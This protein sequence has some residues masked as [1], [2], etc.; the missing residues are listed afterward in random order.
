MSDKSRSMT[1]LPA[2]CIHFKGSTKI[3]LTL[4]Y[5]IQ[6][7]KVMQDT[8]HMQIRFRLKQNVNYC[9]KSDLLCQNWPYFSNCFRNLWHNLQAILN[10]KE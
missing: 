5:V 10:L 4:V 2:E 6:I 8:L 1:H 3:C 9:L 7:I